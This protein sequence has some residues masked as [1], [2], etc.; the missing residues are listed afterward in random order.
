MEIVIGIGLLGLLAAA[1]GLPAFEATIGLLLLTPIA[2]FPIGMW[3]GPGVLPYA[4]AFASLVVLTFLVK[5]K[6]SPT[7]QFGSFFTSFS[8]LLLFLA[9]FSFFSYLCHLWPDFYQMGE[10][11]RDYALLAGVIHSPIDAQEPWLAGAPL[12]Y[13]LYW[14]RFGHFLHTVFKLPVWEV[15]HQ[16]QSFTFALLATSVFMLLRSVARLPVW[17]AM[18]GALALTIGSNYEGVQHFITANDYWWGPSRVIPGAINEFPAWSF[19]LGDVHPHYL[20][21]GLPPFLLLVFLRSMQSKRSWAERLSIAGV[22][23]FVGTLW[24]YNS[25]AW[26]VPVWVG[27]S[28]LIFTLVLASTNPK[29]LI[30]DFKQHVRFSNFLSLPCLAIAGL[31]IYLCVSLGLSCLNIVPAEMPLKLVSA[32]IPM[33]T[34]KD[35]LRHWG[36]PLTALYVFSLVR[37]GKAEWYSCGIFA[38]AAVL[39]AGNALALLVVIFCLNL[40]RFIS[41]DLKG[42]PTPTIARLA[43]EAFGMV[44]LLLI[45]FPE[46]CFFDDSYGGENERMNTIFKAYSAAWFML[47]AFVFYLASTIRWKSARLSFYSPWTALIL[48]IGIL[49]TGFFFRVIKLRKDAD[50]TVLPYA[51][52]LSA[53]DK[54]FPGSA[55]AIQILANSWPGVVLEAQG[56]AYDFTSHVATLSGQQSYLGW[57][58]HVNLLLRMYDE[59]NRRTQMTDQIYKEPDCAKKLNLTTQE[60]IKYVVVGPLEKRAYPG[61]SNES[62]SCF[63]PV[64]TVKDYAIFSN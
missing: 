48:V 62:F 55:T 38:A 24:I 64:T 5:G 39:F 35:L 8:P 56:P 12:N 13:Y 7:L 52:G 44:A 1:L 61:I 3:L 16:L 57:A 50:W 49:W 2:A 34:A 60:K 45:I 31:G 4:F 32:P 30:A 47:H 58:N 41:L 40:Y 20:N 36:I 14:Y 10:R 19:L 22:I 18:G 46:I 9:C 25:N 29:T 53:I 17:A 54:R 37:L 26:E 63:K 51:Q 21:L 15:Y 27:L 6:T 33:T 11:L 28:A 59:V 42:E 23:L 43:F